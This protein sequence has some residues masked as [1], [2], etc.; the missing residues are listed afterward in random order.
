MDYGKCLGYS[1][2]LCPNCGRQRLER[3]E[4]G[5]D[6]C[7]KCHWCPQEQRYVESDSLLNLIEDNDILLG[8][9]R[10]AEEVGNGL[11]ALYDK[12]IMDG[13]KR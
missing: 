7:E 6:I 2:T 10:S 8:I 5:K 13:G 12:M 1:E 3:Y 9:Q 11:K 4:S